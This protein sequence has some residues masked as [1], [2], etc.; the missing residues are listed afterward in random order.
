MSYIL[1]ALKKSEKERQR[2]SVPDLLTPED[3]FAG[4]TKKSRLLPYL[5]LGVFVLNA[6]LLAGWLLGNTKKPQ[7]V[8]QSVAPR[9]VQAKAPE[10]AKE[11][12]GAGASAP[13]PSPGPVKIGNPLVLPSGKGPAP[14]PVTP[15]KKQ[16]PVQSQTVQRDQSRITG[17]GQKRG[18]ENSPPATVAPKESRELLP[19]A[20]QQTAVSPAPVKS[21]PV[22]HN[23][24]PIKNK[25][26]S[27]KELPVSLQQNL[28]DFSISTHLYSGD[29]TSRMVR[30]NGQMLREGEHLSAGVKLEEITPDGVIFSFENYRFRV[31]LK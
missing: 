2:G 16:T 1:D 20:P 22:T 14:G 5:I 28:P 17:A 31:G 8:S 26:Y 24:T 11:T 6:G 4:Q 3:A 23:E 15:V 29:A 25:I 18:F 30:I 12:P 10:P 27:L 13:T 19:S 9:Q 21:Q 7:I